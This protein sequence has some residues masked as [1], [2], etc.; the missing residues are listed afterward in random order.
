MK[1]VVYHGKHDMRVDEVDK[2][3]LQSPTDAIIKVTSTAICGSDLHLYDRA[4]VGMKEG[5]IV[6]HEFMGVVE[7]AG[8]GVSHV[9]VGDRVIVPFVIACGTC[10]FCTQGLQ[11][12]CDNTNPNAKIL[13]KTYG[14][15]GAG[16]F[17]Y[18]H[19]FGG[20]DGGQAEYVRVPHADAGLFA[21]PDSM[22]DDHALF[23]T[24]ILPT[25]WMAAVNCDISEG[26][27]ILIAGAGPVGQ[28][29]AASALVQ[30]AGT[31][32]VFDRER[33]RLDKVAE[34]PG[35]VPLEDT[36]RGVQKAIKALTGGRGADAVI[37]A[38]GM[39]AHG[40]GVV[41]AYDRAKMRLKLQTD[42]VTAL[43]TLIKAAR[44][45][46][47]VSIPG[48]YGGVADKFPIG[49]VFGKGLTMTGGQT[50]VH[51][52]VP[53]LIDLI[54][55]N[56]LDPSRIISAH[57]PLDKAPEAYELFKDKKELKVVL[58]P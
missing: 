36:G 37:D 55:N 46:A 10:W 29:A 30:G 44:K 24:D 47:R 31:V 52:F 43:R 58:Q 17:G 5:D 35:V 1:A 23:L 11:S 7:D 26:D 50:H 42:R 28:L 27:T 4:I 39:E 15:S 57:M 20:Y 48:V 45:G 56:S 14:Q 32:V 25:G 34:L 54:G 9:S 13:E 3:H 16:L 51:R 18:T 19:L 41:G 21:I 2:P 22:D 38:V 40:G 6:G 49:A 53:E 33:S 8:Q 12:L